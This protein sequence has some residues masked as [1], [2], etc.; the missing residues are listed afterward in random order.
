[1]KKKLDALLQKL[2]PPKKPE[3]PVLEEKELEVFGNK[4]KIKTFN[5]T[6]LEEAL[7]EAPDGSLVMLSAYTFVQVFHTDPAQTETCK[8]PEGDCENCPHFIE[9]MEDAYDGC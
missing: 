9:E 6:R 1:M 5:P 4:V 3:S 2:F 8:N 7:D